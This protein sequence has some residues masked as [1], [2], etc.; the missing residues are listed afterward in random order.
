MAK[1]LH[2]FDKNRA[3]KFFRVLKDDDDYI[4]IEEEEV[5]Y[6]GYY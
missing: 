6:E 4:I 5:L 3:D 2:I 1:K